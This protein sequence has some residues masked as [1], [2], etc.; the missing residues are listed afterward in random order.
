MTVFALFVLVLLAV[1]FLMYGTTKSGR[2]AVW[3]TA[4]KFAIPVVITLAI[5]SAIV[6]VGFHGGPIG[7]FG[8]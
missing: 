8:S 6:L 7:I 2:A 5:V 1:T 4:R 3:K